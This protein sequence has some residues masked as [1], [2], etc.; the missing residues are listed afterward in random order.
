MQVSGSLTNTDGNNPTRSGRFHDD[1]LLDDLSAGQ[2]VQLNLDGSFDTY[3]QLINGATGEVIAFNDDGGPGLNSEL[4]FTVENDVD[5][6]VRATSFGSS[7]TGDYNL[8]TTGGDLETVTDRISGS[9]THGDG[10]NPTRSGRFH[11]DYLLNGLS[12]GQEVQLNLN[13]S[14][15][16]YLQL[17]NG[18]TGQ[19]IDFNDDGGS[20]RNA[21]LIF[22][23]ENDVD[24]LVRATS[25]GS[26]VTGD[27]SLTTTGGIF[28]E[29]Q[30]DHFAFVTSQS[31]TIL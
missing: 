5:Y 23:V 21:E 12:A 14:F 7:V 20:G 6:L 8:T 16:N 26:S 22:T 1:Y 4:N 9:L 27:Y 10:N 18:A 13:S 3:L 30:D 17:V 11:D 15:D 28:T 24:Y 29:L 19:V 25:F 31:E 2:E